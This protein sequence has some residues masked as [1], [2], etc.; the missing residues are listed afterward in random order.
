MVMLV[1]YLSVQIGKT[2]CCQIIKSDYDVEL[3]GLPAGV[4]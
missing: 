1:G 4:A 3:E 2:V